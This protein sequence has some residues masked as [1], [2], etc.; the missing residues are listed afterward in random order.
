MNVTPFSCSQNS[1]TSLRALRVTNKRLYKSLSV[2]IIPRSLPRAHFSYP[3]LKL[4]WRD[5]S[6]NLLL[7]FLGQGWQVHLGQEPVHFLLFY[8]TLWRI[9]CLTKRL[10]Y[11]LNFLPEHFPSPQRLLG[12]DNTVVF[13]LWAKNLPAASR[14][15]SLWCPPEANNHLFCCFYIKR[16][17]SCVG[18]CSIIAANEA[19]R[20]RAIS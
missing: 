18:L 11:F 8:S 16:R 15:S 4:F 10:K 5:I 2:A 14:C 9:F 12:C 13:T 19:H 6:T 3:L 20:R 17:V 1:T 7:F